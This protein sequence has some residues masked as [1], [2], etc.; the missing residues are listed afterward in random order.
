MTMRISLIVSFLLLLMVV[1]AI[2]AEVFS[3]IVVDVSDGDTI[4]VLTPDEQQ[5]KVR[6]YGVDCPEKKQPYGG[7]AK[8]F[9][10]MPCSASMYNR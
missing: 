2:G 3:G 7:K 10:K 1:P 4:T 9:T 8:A 5:V 6:L